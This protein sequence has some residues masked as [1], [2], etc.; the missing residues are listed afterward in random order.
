MNKE[1][2]PQSAVE[3]V[4]TSFPVAHRNSLQSMLQP[5]E[6]VQAA[7]MLDLNSQLQFAEGYV[8]ITRQRV[9]ACAPG[10]SNW[11]GWEIR[12]EL[13]LRHTD[14]AG[15]G[16]LE[17][18]TSEARLGCWRYTLAQNPQALRVLQQFELI[19]QEQSHGPVTTEAVALTC[20][21]CHSPM[22]PDDDECQVC[23]RE[24]YTAPSTWTLFRL[25]RFA[26]PY[27]SRL[28]LGFVLTLLSTEATLIQPYMTMPL[29]DEILIPYQNGQPI[30]YDLARVYLGGL[31]LAA[32]IAWGLGWAKT[33]ILALVS[34]R[35]GRD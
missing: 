6:S 27:K 31:L 22:S 24:A 23:A 16:L 14:H 26:K 34:E 4:L 17:L 5:G 25:W 28:L 30:N 32:L 7:L 20:P 9:L 8:V 33:Y 21:S 10:E 11:Q 12:P 1:N 13:S 35:I 2:M 18:V 19:Q 15:V 29:M 3:A